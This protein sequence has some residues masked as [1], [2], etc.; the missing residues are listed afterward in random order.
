MK[1][2][3]ERLL[4]ELVDQIGEILHGDIHIIKTQRDINSFIQPP[5]EYKITYRLYYAEGYCLDLNKIAVLDKNSHI[6][7]HNYTVFQDWEG[8]LKA[9]LQKIY[10]YLITNLPQT[11]N[12]EKAI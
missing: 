1:K 10:Q 6:T 4:F 3:I 8:F 2:S 5:E 7:G 12:D 11:N 9:D